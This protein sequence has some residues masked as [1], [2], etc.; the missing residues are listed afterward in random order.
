VTTL[1]L[2][3]TGG[4]DHLSFNDVGL[5]GFQ[6]IQDPLD[7]STVTHHS[8]MDTYDHLIPADLMQ[9]SA[10]ISSIVVQ[11]ANGNEMLPRKPIVTTKAPAA[12][13]N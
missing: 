7:Y 3:N 12:S 1:S 11:A 9:A 10:V 2:R 4:T 8:T 13:G 6:F 5:P